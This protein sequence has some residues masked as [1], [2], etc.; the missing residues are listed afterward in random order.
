MKEEKVY[1]MDEYDGDE[2]HMYWCTKERRNEHE[3]E[4]TTFPGVT[5]RYKCKHCGVV[6]NFFGN[7]VPNQKLKL[8]KRAF[9]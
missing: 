9:K 3:L 4:V 7:P 1:L 5:K 8:Y 2:P 6:V